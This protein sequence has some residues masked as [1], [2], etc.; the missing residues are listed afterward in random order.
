VGESPALVVWG[1]RATRNGRVKDDDTVVLGAAG[2]RR[3]EGGVSQ[4]SVSCTTSEADTVDVESFGSTLPQLVLHCGL[5]GAVEDS[6]NNCGEKASGSA[7]QVHLPV[8]TDLVEPVTVE[9]PVGISEVEADATRGV[10]GV[11]DVDGGRDLGV[12]DESTG[13]VVGLVDDVPCETKRCQCYC[14]ERKS[15]EY[16]VQ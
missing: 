15:R 16:G 9:G 1:L 3:W 7:G 11:H 2:V 6:V 13:E 8:G 14:N 4:K 10:V 5:E 12:G